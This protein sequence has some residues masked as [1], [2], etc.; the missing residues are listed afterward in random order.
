MR[1]EPVKIHL[2]ECPICGQP[3]NKTNT[4][5]VPWFL[6]KETVTEKGTGLR[7]KQL[8]FTISPG[9]RVRLHAGRGVLPEPLEE[10]HEDHDLEPAPEDEFAR[11]HLWCASREDK[12]S[13]L[14]AIFSD[15]FTDERLLQQPEDLHPYHGQ[16]IFIDEKFH[17]SL[18]RLFVHSIFWRCSVGRFDGF[19][20]EL[21]IEKKLLENV[22]TAFSVPGFERTKKKEGLPIVHSFPLITSYLGF[23]EGADVTAYHVSTN[24][25]RWPYMVVA[26]RW[27]FQLFEKEKHIRSTNE[28]LYGLRDALDS[29][30]L[31]PQIKGTSHAVLVNSEDSKR[32]VEGL[33]KEITDATLREEMKGA[34]RV[35]RGL[36]EQAFKSS[37]KREHEDFVVGRFVVH[38]RE[39]KPPLESCELALKDLA[40]AMGLPFAS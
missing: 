19:R 3:T 28:Y 40:S 34:R 23:D 29:A 39:G 21:P 30:G 27:V 33:R 37:P 24:Q 4:H 36:F 12:V 9:N 16:R 15:V 10:L 38:R 6:I 25:M 13:H 2:P 31:Y 35:T 11:D 20:L 1:K 5:L 18:Y 8:T 7:D 26:A 22:Q 14:E 17:P 32:F